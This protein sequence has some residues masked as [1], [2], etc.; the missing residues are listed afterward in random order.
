MTF[1]NKILSDKNFKIKFF[2]VFSF[3]VSWLSISSG[4]QN[5]L[6]IYSNEPI[7]ITQVL[8]FFRAALNLFVFPLLCFI[9]VRTLI[10][11]DKFKSIENLLILAP[12]IYFL[13][14]I[15]GL[16]YTS[17]SIENLIFVT[18]VT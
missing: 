1:I 4:Y 9:L 3:S 12:F 2:L 16:F 8:N 15:P 7:T 14:Q 5:L 10:K 13:S 18:K 6:I 17:N 11:I